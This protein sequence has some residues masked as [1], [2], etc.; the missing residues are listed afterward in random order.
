MTTLKDYE[1]A[2]GT[3]EVKTLAKMLGVSVMSYYNWRRG[4]T[5]NGR[6]A[7]VPEYIR[8]SMAAQI[9]LRKSDGLEKNAGD[10]SGGMLLCCQDCG[11]QD[12]TVRNDICPYAEEIN[13]SRIP[14]V[15]CPDCYHERCMDI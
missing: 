1:T 7:K 11:K 4:T 5:S 9:E 8:I 15:I 2:M 6:P 14:I 12:E 10:E 3:T 13:G